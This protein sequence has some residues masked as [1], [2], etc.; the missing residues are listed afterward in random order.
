VLLGGVLFLTA[1]S[2]VETAT[3]TTLQ[4]TT[5]TP[6]STTSTATPIVTATS[7]APS[8]TAAQTTTTTPTTTWPPDPLQG[9]ALDL[10]ATDLHQPTAVAS[11]PGDHR[12]FVVERRGRIRIIEDGVL[13]EEPF[14]DIEDSVNWASGIEQGTL[15]LAFHPAYATNGRFFVYYT[16]SS[17]ER[18]LVEFTVSEDPSVTDPATERLLLTRPQPSDIIRHYGGHLEFG[19]DG[20]LYASL[21]DGAGLD[22]GQDPGTVLGAILRLDVDGGDTYAIPADNPFVDG[23]GA[24]EVWAFGLRN[25][26]QFAIDGETG[27]M[28]IGDVGLED[29]EEINVVALNE[30]GANFGWP[31][32][33]G[34]HCFLLAGCD[35]ADYTLPWIEYS[36]DEG[37]SVTGGRVYRGRAIPELLGHYFYAD[38]CGLWI[39]SVELGG[40]PALVQDWSGDLSHAGQVQSFGVDDAGELY[41]V[42]FAGELWK[43]VPRR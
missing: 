35:V 30:G 41:V 5:T 29:W 40:D 1:C 2:G 4:P 36:H 25:P 38:W 31:D 18:R 14:L 22:N 10:V 26:W 39:R 23:G 24:P 8:T 21:G 11:P 33:E 12:L 7:Q 27:S 37:C 13:L 43:I 16:G 19:P 15:G 9:L 28:V 20:L 34:A 42:N 6:P 3:S 32:T 17:D